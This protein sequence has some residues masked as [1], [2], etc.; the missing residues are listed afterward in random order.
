MKG[1]KE[2]FLK[3]KNQIYCFA[4][5]LDIFSKLL[6]AGA[7]IIQYRNKIVNDRVFY[8][9]A[10]EMLSLIRERNDIIFIIN[11][12]V[13]IALK[14]K[15]DGV[16]IGKSDEP[17]SNIIQRVPEDIIIGVSVDNEHEAIL[18]ANAGATYL[19]AGAV[20]PTKTK[21]GVP[22]IGTDGLQR[23]VRS[24]HIPVV[25]IG[26]ITPDNIHEVIKTGVQYIAMISNIND[27]D[28]IPAKFKVCSN[29]MNRGKK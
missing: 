29:L 24:V 13:D 20:F 8:Q 16:H 26:G 3:G 10:N 1:K 6:A 22:V 25:A 28:D 12:R 7:R 23:I 4:D 5:N 21:A 11:D 18:A 19:G 15:A 27:S 14:V 9:T 2:L 17:Y